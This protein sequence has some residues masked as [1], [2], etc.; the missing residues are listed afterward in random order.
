[1]NKKNKPSLWDRLRT[2][3]V[4]GY[5]IFGIIVILFRDPISILFADLMGIDPNDGLYS[6]I[7]YAFQIAL[8]VFWA[9]ITVIGI[10]NNR[11][12]ILTEGR[13]YSTD[14][15][16][17]NKSYSE[18]IRFFTTNDTYKM[19]INDLP[20]IDWKH[21]DG[22]IF[23]KVK[24]RYGRY[25]LL[26]RKSMDD[27]HSC[28]FARPGS[29]KTTTQAATSALRFNAKRIKGG[30]GVFGISIKGDLLYLVKGKRTNIKL[31]T[32]DRAEGSCHYDPLEGLDQMSTTEKRIFIENLSI[33]VCPDEQG[34]NAAFFVNG[35]RDYF[36]GIALYLIYLHD[37]GEIE[38]KLT[39]PEIVEKI[40]EGN[41]FDVTE[42]IRDS[43]CEIAGEYTNS[44]MGSSE[45]NVSGI[46]NHLCKSVR[47][48]NT[49][50]LKTLFDG[51]GDCI[52]PDDLATHDIYIDVP[53]DKYSVY[54]KAIGIIVSN[55]L[56]AFMRKP[57]VASGEKVVPYLFLLDE[58]IQ[59]HLDASILLSAMMVLRSKKVSLA[60]YMQSVASLES[61]YGEAHAREIIDLCSYISVFNA[62]D[63]KSREFFQKLVGNR[64]ML[65][66]STSLSEPSGTSNITSSTSVT[67]EIEPIFQAADFGDLNIVDKNTGKVTHRVLVYANG[68][69]IIGETTP[70]YE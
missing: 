43:D 56:Q 47:P 6:I 39:F 28:C 1:M 41:V 65:K 25:H 40:L 5:M 33:T 57:D 70:C 21:A 53:Q 8:I 69:Y 30:C 51:K 60:L 2:Y 63:P 67:T 7:R 13:S 17:F 15:S 14:H 22:M 16:K 10:R 42:T 36:C 4:L 68:K 32:P 23:C 55:F 59:L 12:N 61:E 3:H 38:G 35:A 19:N 37:T 20:V 26:R 45:K 49:G 48:F 24:D 66:A 52:S 64:K 54:G 46:Y 27:G 62:Q 29:G 34:E 9:A 44:Y 58:V 31:F 11:Y 50:A 18:L